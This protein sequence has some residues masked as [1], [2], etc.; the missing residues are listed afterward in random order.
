M[1][2]ASLDNTIKIWDIISGNLIGNI[3][4]DNHV[5][6]IDASPEGELVATTFA[7]KKEINLWHSLLGVSPWG[8]DI[9][10]HVKFASKINE[11]DKDGRMRFY[12]D[13][14]MK[15]YI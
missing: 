6:S 7:N 14:F 12:L 9:P 11:T 2:S 10:K 15:V 4:L 13:R 3:A 8:N 5:T 1:F